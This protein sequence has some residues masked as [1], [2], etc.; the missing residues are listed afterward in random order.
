MAQT[1]AEWGD[2]NES[3]PENVPSGLGARSATWLYFPLSPLHSLGRGSAR[4]AMR[5]YGECCPGRGGTTFRMR[6]D[7]GGMVT[8]AKPICT[9]TCIAS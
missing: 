7:R 9:L 2:A 5:L 3:N 6:T 8:V 4:Y 1:L